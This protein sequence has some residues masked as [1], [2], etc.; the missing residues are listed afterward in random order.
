MKVMCRSL[1]VILAASPNRLHEEAN[2]PGAH[3]PKLNCCR[4][5]QIVIVSGNKFENSATHDFA[6]RISH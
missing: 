6:Q 5:L 2:V 1:V 4:K 3:P